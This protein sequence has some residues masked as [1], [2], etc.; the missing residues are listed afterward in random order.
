M[1][2]IYIIFIF[3]IAFL[4]GI[5]SIS[6][7]QDGP[8]S[9][10]LK[11]NTQQEKNKQQTKK[12]STPFNKYRKMNIIKGAKKDKYGNP[13]GADFDLVKNDGFKGLQ[14]AVLH[15]YTGENFDFQAPTK[16][17]K[18]KGFSIKRWQNTPPSASELK[19]VLDKSCQ[20]WIISDCSQKLNA[21][22][23]Q[24]IKDFFNE[25]KGV[26]IW[27]DNAPYFAD[28]NYVSK[29]L[30]GTS[31]SGNTKG[32]KKVSLQKNSNV[33]MKIGILPS[34][35]IT[36]GIEQL[37]EG[38]TIATVQQNSVLEPLIYGSSGNL[39]AAIYQQ[40]NKRLIIDGGFTRLFHKWD[41]AGTGRYVK[42][43]AAWLVNYD[44]FGDIV[45]NN[46]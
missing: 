17:L 44:R 39:V 9:P 27:G 34:H 38:I 5:Q 18:E 13:K 4:V 3:S 7:S 6:Y 29:A 16:A 40:N 23:L 25:G 1:K 42:N 10:K 33:Q 19:K 46:N 8:F 12:Q 22:H 43:A 28:A 11:E 24:V 37:Y 36:T 30:I 21:Q 45:F 15:L 35:D 41:T 20:L 2:K 26:Y 14:I 31:M 32:D